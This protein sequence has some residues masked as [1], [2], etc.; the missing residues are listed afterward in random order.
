MTTDLY[1]AISQ[2][3]QVKLEN[4]EDDN[5]KDKVTIFYNIQKECMSDVRDLIKECPKC[6]LIWMKTLGCN[7]VTCG[8]K[9]SYKDYQYLKKTLKYSF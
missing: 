3:I 2:L 5:E 1:L 4:F 6:G 8:Q 9:A 7:T